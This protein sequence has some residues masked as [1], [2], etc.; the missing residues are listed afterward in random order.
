MERMLRKGNGRWRQNPE[1][2]VQDKKEKYKEI[3]VKL[4]RKV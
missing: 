2:R 1:N 4:K 3:N